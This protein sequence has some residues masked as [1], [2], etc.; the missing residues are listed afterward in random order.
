MLIFGS[1]SVNKQIL[2]IVF[3]LSEIWSNRTE[4]LLL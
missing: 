1:S 4:M 3:A 2:N